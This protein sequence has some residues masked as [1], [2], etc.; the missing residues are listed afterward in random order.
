MKAKHSPIKELASDEKPS[1]Y[2]APWVQ[3]DSELVANLMANAPL[4][5][6]MAWSRTAFCN[7]MPPVK[8]EHR[9]PRASGALA[10]TPLLHSLLCFLCCVASWLLARILS[11]CIRPLLLCVEWP[12][13]SSPG[14][15]SSSVLGIS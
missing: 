8:R 7:K 5:L 3:Q 1:N 2:D 10:R 6:N 9:V 14:P 4:K 13:G 11:T 12:V 15:S